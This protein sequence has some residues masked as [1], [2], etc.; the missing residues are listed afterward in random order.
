MAV[1]NA[2]GALHDA[3]VQIGEVIRQAAEEK[4]VTQPVLGAAVGLDA[5]G[6]SRMY[7]GARSLTVARVMQV[8]DFLDLPRGTVFRRAGYVGDSTDPTESIRT[9][10]SL[11]PTDRALLVLL[12]H[13]LSAPTQASSAG[14]TSEQIGNIISMSN[15]FAPEVRAA[16][17]AEVPAPATRPALV[18]EVTKKQ[19]RPRKKP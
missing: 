4:G 7:K 15:R 9:A 17:G 14:Y 1:D 18:E 12:F 8:E 5:S 16:S 19:A 10:E 6:V 3:L 13:R 2:A 11:S